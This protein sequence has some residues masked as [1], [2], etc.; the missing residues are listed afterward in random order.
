MKINYAARVDIGPKTTNDDRVLAAGEIINMTSCSSS[1]QSP[2]VMAVCDGC[3]GYAGGYIAAETVLTVLCT[4]DASLLTDEEQLAPLLEQCRQS[5]MDKKA[6]MPEFEAMCT[7][8]AGCVFHEDRTLIFHSGDSRVY[9]FDKWGLARMTRDHSVVQ[10]LIDM[11]EIAPEEAT[12]HPR[13]NVITRCIGVSSPPPEIYLSSNPINPGEKYLFCSDGLWET[14]TDEEIS[15]ILG[16]DM[17]L[18]EMANTLV[19]KAI[20]QGAY[21]NISVC[22]CARDGEAEPAQ[23]KPFIL[24]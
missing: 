17:T 1:T 12:T 15:K 20:I 4:A 19:E 16:S 23:K 13:R 22:I 10:E 8:V 11:G 14:V 7:T 3:G 5:V 6:Q 2:V 9:R 18:T 24:D 21:D